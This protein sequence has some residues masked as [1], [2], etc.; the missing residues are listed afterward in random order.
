MTFD[1]DLGEPFKPFEQ[2]MAVLPPSSMD[3]VPS[4]YRDLMYD[5]SSPILHYYPVDFEQDLNGKK[6]GWEA[7]MKIPFVDEKRLI[8]AMDRES[9]STWTY[10]YSNSHN[11]FRSRTQV[12][13]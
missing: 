5:P 7:V 9:F 6:H 3:H 1:F 11:L 13:T 12:D 4:A 10:T 2:L 8:Q